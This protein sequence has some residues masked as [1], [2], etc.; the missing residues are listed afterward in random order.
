MS[1]H[2]HFTAARLWGALGIAAIA[3][4]AY[5]A[6]LVAS[7][8]S[9]TVRWLQLSLH[10]L[11]AFAYAWSTPLCVKIAN[12]Y[13]ERSTMRLAWRLIAASAAI[14]VIRHLFESLAVAAG[15][16]DTR[17]TTLVSL[18]QIP[19]VVSLILLTAG[20]VAVWS[21]FTSIGMG[22]RFRRAD[23]LFIAIILA[24]VPS[25]L[26]LRD[27]MFDR[28]SVYPIIRHLQVAS[29]MLLAAPALVSLVLHRIT[30]EMGGGP[31]ATSLRCLVAFLVMRLLALFLGLSPGIP[32]F[33]VASR[34][35]WWA[36]A[37]LFALA[38]F[39]R[40]QVTLAAS[41][42]ADRYEAD[43]DAELAGVTHALALRSAQP[44][45]K[46]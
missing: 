38:V 18:R 2:S 15:W 41:E 19:I 12:D 1:V 30:Q 3:G 17:L 22:L 20:L 33:T 32:V 11:T 29:P 21:S 35:V 10:L 7:P 6:L 45:A 44:A 26:S 34:T 42:L 36:A 39:H 4:T 37:W 23:A 8:G 40:W 25:I 31:L 5:G 28:Q 24:F 27:E 46:N 9:L 14:A 16:I 13:R 43:P